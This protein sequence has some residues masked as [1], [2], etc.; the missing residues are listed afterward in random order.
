VGRGEEGFKTGY[1][2]VTL[3]LLLLLQDGNYGRMNLAFVCS[4][5][6]EFLQ[7][8]SHF[9]LTGYLGVTSRELLIV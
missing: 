3:L 6:F 2:C 7:K 8:I 5:S 9:L 1:S 4:G